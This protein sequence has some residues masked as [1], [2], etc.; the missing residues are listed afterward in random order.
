MLEIE[1]AKICAEQIDLKGEKCSDNNCNDVCVSRHSEPGKKI[2]A[3]GYCNPSGQCAC[4]WY[5]GPGK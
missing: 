4:F 2:Y 1:G 5:C 3:R